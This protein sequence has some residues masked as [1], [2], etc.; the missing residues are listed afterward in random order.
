MI[1]QI[2]LMTLLIFTVS[3]CQSTRNGVGT[4]ESVGTIGGAVLGGLAGAQFGDGRGQ[5]I[6]VGIGTLAG[7]YFGSEIGKSLDRADMVYME[8]A[9]QRA[10]S[11]PIGETVTWSNPETG[12]SGEITP[13]RDGTSSAGRYCRE[14]KQVIYVG[15]QEK[16][17][18][19]QACRIEG[20]DD[21]WE[22]VS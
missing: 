7:A 18:I 22:I 5:L 3:A 1:R 4:K 13:T 10:H 20:S 19:G 11:A 14:Y 2:A 16:E 15:G 17:A 8:R 9:E 6:A 21:E 12:N